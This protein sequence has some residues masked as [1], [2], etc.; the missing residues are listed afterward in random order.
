MTRL[1]TV[2]VLGIEVVITPIALMVIL[3]MTNIVGV[4]HNLLLD[5]TILTVAVVLPEDVAN[6]HA[7]TIIANLSSQMS[8]ALHASVWA[9][10]LSTATCSPL[11]SVWNST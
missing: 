2:V 10:W 6:W 4:A 8:N 1:L 5:L 9:M 7:R 11:L 3:T